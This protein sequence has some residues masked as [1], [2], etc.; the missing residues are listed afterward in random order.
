MKRLFSSLPKNTITITNNA[1]KKI[2]D[3]IKKSNTM[4]MLFSVKS[5]GCNGFNYS[6]ETI[7]SKNMDIF[8]NKPQPNF[9]TKNSNTV[10]IDPISELYLMGTTIDYLEED[11]SNGIYESK[12]VYLPDKNIASSCGCG[13]SFSPK[14]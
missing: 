10:Y 7:N 3:I 2:N 4:G 9:V 12:F 1:W 11:Y 5:G 14:I 6:F 13:V 8:D